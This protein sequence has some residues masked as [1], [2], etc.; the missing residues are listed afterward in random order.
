[1]LVAEIMQG[2]VADVA[3]GLFCLVLNYYLFWFAT[4]PYTVTVMAI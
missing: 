1:M 3:M 4:V 2:F